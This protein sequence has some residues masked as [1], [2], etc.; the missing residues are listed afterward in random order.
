M[1]DYSRKL[2]AK[3]VDSI[4]AAQA[5]LELG[6]SDICAGRA[7]YAMFYIAEALLTEKGLKFSKHSGVHAAFGEQFAKTNIL[8]A[9]YHRWLIDAFDKRLVGDYGVDA[10]IENDV[11]S[12]M[13]S[14][15][16]E[17]LEAARV[18]LEM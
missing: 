8:D 12:E 5:L 14:Q 13:I 2:L 11:A 18:Y 17:F 1:K 9:R 4:E 15:A 16:Q 10:S 3:A 7:Y 6:K